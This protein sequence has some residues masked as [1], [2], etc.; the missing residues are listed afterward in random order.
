MKHTFY[1]F[2]LITLLMGCT[3]TPPST[4]YTLIPQPQKITYGVGTNFTLDATTPIYCATPDEETKRAASFLKDYLQLQTGLVLSIVDKKPTTPALVLKQ[5]PDQLP[6]EGY[7]LVITGKQ[8]SLHASS[9]AGLFYAVQVF[10]KLLSTHTSESYSL[11]AVEITDAPR[12]AYRGMMLDVSRHFKS[13]SFLKRYIDLLAL[14]Q[15]NKLHL[16]LTDD[17]GWRVEI[18]KY[19][20]LIAVGSQRKETTQSF[21]TGERDGIPHGG[22]YTQEELKELVR[23]A[24]ERYIEIIPEIDLPGHML[25]ALASYPQLGCTGGPY[26]VAP[27]WGIHKDVLCAGNEQTYQFLKDVFTEIMAIFPSKY[28]HIGGDECPK[29]RWEKCPKCQAKIKELGF[30]D[31]PQASKESKLQSHLTHYLARLCEE[32]GRKLAGWDEIIEGGLAPN[33]TVFSWRGEAGGVYAAQQGHDVVLCPN[34][35]FYFDYYQTANTGTEPAAF[36][37]VNS[38]EEVYMYN[39]IPAEL[40]D[41]AKQHILGAQANLW[42]EMIPTEAHTEYMTL[43]RLAALSENQWSREAG[44][45]YKDFL[46][47]L[48][49]LI[50]LYE[51]LGYHY[52]VVGFEPQ[53]TMLMSSTP[54]TLEVELSTLDQAPIHYSLDG[55]T[56]SASSPRYTKPLVLQENTLLQAKAIRNNWTDTNLYREYFVLHKGLSADVQLQTP[57]SRYFNPP[58]GAQILVDGRRGN[59]AHVFG[60]VTNWVGFG[61][62]FSVILDLKA[63]QEISQVTTGV[64]LV[65][66]HPE[67]TYQIELS[68]DGSNYQEVYNEMHQLPVIGDVIARFKT[69]S[70]RYVQVR[71]TAAQHPH[72]VIDEII[73]E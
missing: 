16:H 71:L 36:P 38:L 57:I 53:A 33:A 8:V 5:I 58:E 73:I 17:Q 54:H 3:T 47:R 51:K 39:L 42:C 11:A 44:K 34:S 10:R 13:V 68:T 59:D 64:L 48:Q 69:Q 27:S 19:P 63:S 35:T 4:S 9:G 31:T 26:E 52:S 50:A 15:I 56:P 70:A 60:N 1:Y 23:Y 62:E 45:D 49:A 18:K 32:K 28:M 72:L 21:L 43:P 41:K 40:D 24:Q 7:Q 2:L 22:Y 55:T 67:V 30:T 37:E 25:A 65:P 46:D 6:D 66:H 29:T 20:N 12:F 61:K 14:H